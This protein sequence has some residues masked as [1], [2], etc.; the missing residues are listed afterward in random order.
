MQVKDKVCV[1]TGAASGIGEAVARADLRN[2]RERLAN[3]AGDIDGLAVTADVGEEAD[4]KALIAASEAKYGP[5]D[6]FFSNAGLSRKGQESASDADWDVSASALLPATAIQ[7]IFL[8]GI[9]SCV[10]CVQEV[11]GRGWNAHDF[12]GGESPCRDVQTGRRR[13]SR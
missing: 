3:L 10:L 1:V 6:I 7:T 9:R 11:F 13:T 4:I 5:V 8:R 12:S 2:S